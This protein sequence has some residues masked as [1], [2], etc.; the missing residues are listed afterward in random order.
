MRRVGGELI[1]SASL[2][3]VACDGTRHAPCA[4]I[5]TTISYNTQTA[6]LL[7]INH[8]SLYIYYILFYCFRYVALKI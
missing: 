5:I 2:G 3:C 7:F 4:A 1:V 8:Y 6:L